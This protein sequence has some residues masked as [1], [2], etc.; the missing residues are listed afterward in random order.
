MN[1]AVAS[2]PLHIESV[3]D[4][5]PAETWAAWTDAALVSQWFAP[6]S[7]RAEVLDYDVRA[8]G[9]YRIRMHDDED[10][11]HTVAGEFVEVIPKRRLVMSWAWEGEETTESTVT[12][13]FDA[14]D[15]GTRVSIMHEGLPSEESR[16]AH[17]QGWHGCLGNLS[18]RVGTL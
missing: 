5:S 3:I 6:G 8:G 12:V 11:A 14:C 16:T 7:L 13:A 4:A 10:G 15:G 18:D 17:E 9:R 1:T 2:P